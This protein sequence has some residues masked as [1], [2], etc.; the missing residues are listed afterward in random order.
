MQRR[1]LLS[2]INVGVAVGALIVWFRYPRD[3]YYALYA[4]FGW[5]LVSFSLTWTI[6][7]APARGFAAPAAAAPAAPGGTTSGTLTPLPSAPRP[8]GGGAS[9]PDAEPIPFCIYCATNLPDDADRCPACG[10]LVPAFA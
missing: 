1:A 8:S 6:R 10:R 4:L 9:A 7:A 5:F 2:I 3:S